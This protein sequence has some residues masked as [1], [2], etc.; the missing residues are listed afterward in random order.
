MMSRIA[1]RVAR[2]SFV[3]G[4][5]GYWKC[6][7]RTVPFCLLK[8]TFACAMTG[9]KPWS[10]N[11]R[12]QN[13][14]AKNPRLSSR[15]SMSITKAPL[16]LVSVKIIQSPRRSAAPHPTKIT[17]RWG[18][19]KISLSQVEGRRRGAGETHRIPPRL[20]LVARELQVVELAVR[21]GQLVTEVEGHLGAVLAAFGRDVLV[22]PRVIEDVAEGHG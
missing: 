20:G 22:D 11:S 16:S 2:T 7:P 17:A 4:V 21:L 5:G 14:R 18:Y 9:F 1:P 12:W 3:S 10:A 15:R 13:A 6:M 19:W 8:A